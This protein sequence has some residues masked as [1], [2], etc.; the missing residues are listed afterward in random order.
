VNHRDV[1]QRAIDY[2]G[3]L[4]KDEACE[5]AGEIADELRAILWATPLSAA[6]CEQILEA[7]WKSEGCPFGDALKAM[8]ALRDRLLVSAPATGS[9]EAIRFAVFVKRRI[10]VRIAEAQ[11]LDPISRSTA[12]YQAGNPDMESEWAE[13]EKESQNG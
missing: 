4:G 7:H 11:K 3:L 8:L 6:E 10:G 12:F 1:L 5:S 13:F 9:G 2:L